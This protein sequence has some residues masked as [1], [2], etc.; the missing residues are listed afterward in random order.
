MVTDYSNNQR[1]IHWLTCQKEKFCQ[2]L[3]K[4]GFIK[5]FPHW[6]FPLLSQKVEFTD[7][8]HISRIHSRTSSTKKSPNK[9]FSNF[10]VLLEN[11][12]HTT[13]RALVISHC[14][15]VLVSAL[16]FKINFGIIL[17]LLLL[18]MVPSSIPN[19]GPGSKQFPHI[20]I[21]YA[22]LINV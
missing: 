15:F 1:L 20:Y 3:V 21:Y 6:S 13:Q 10:S 22:E 16:L 18:L 17:L 14:K 8:P 19:I 5:T 11:A 2:N 9:Y 12:I 4:H 7:V